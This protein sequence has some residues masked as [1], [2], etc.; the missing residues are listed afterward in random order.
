MNSHTIHTEERTW[1]QGHDWANLWRMWKKSWHPPV[2]YGWMPVLSLV[3]GNTALYRIPPLKMHA[4]THTH[5]HTHTH[6]QTFLTPTA[7]SFL[8]I[9]A[10]ALTAKTKPWSVKL[11]KDGCVHFLIL[12]F[13]KGRKI[14]HPLSES[15]E[16]NFNIASINRGHE[17]S[18]RWPHRKVI[19]FVHKAS[20]AC[21]C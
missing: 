3:P 14:Q 4:R 19:F 18:P 21:K 13:D 10:E 5:T 2:S 17:S 12:H 11:K 9:L 20:K 7:T 1:K 15:K 8:Q 6:M 16:W